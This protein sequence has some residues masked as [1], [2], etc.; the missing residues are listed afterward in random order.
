MK[1]LFSFFSWKNACVDGRTWC[2]RNKFM[3]CSKIRHFEESTSTD[4]QNFAESLLCFNS[5]SCRF[6]EFSIKYKVRVKFICETGMQ[7][8]NS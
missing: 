6:D 4:A 8:V 5:S 1:Q 3:N 2:N 7:F